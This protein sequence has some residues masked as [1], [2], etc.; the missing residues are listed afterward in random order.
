MSRVTR[1]VLVCVFIFSYLGLL[2]AQQRPP[3]ASNL[4][5]CITGAFYN[6][7]KYKWYTYPNNC[8]EKVF[9]TWVSG[10]GLQGGSLEIKSE[11]KQDI[12]RSER[13]VDEMGGVKAY[14]CPEH[15]IPVDANDR[16]IVKPV[17]AFRC[18]YQGF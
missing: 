14:A 5:S 8:T 16:H 3:Y 13:E 10:N 15:Y 4:N 7:Q 6:P 1:T 2:H 18:K 11:G 12:G 9:L 17:T